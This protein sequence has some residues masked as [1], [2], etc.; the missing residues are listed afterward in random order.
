M[1]EPFKLFRPIS[2]RL[3][4]RET[5]DAF[6]LVGVL[7]FPAEFE[8]KE[9][10]SYVLMMLGDHIE[11]VP[12]VIDDGLPADMV[13]NGIGYA[14]QAQCWR[15]TRAAG[16]L[17][18]RFFKAFPESNGW[19]VFG[20]SMLPIVSMDHFNRSHAWLDVSAGKFF[21]IQAPFD[22]VGEAIASTLTS[23]AV[24]P[25]VRGDLYAV[26]AIESA[27]R[28]VYLRHALLLADLGAGETSLDEFREAIR[29]DREVFQIRQLSPDMNYARYLARLRDRGGVIEIG[30]R[31]VAELE[32]ASLLAQEVIR[33][34]IPEE[35][36]AG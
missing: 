33:E 29:E 34:V 15:R 11:V 17:T 20:P 14:I 5:A 25:D 28:P 30:V 12:N 24:W 36:A 10:A 27:W 22:A 26:P 9:S 7:H 32:K 31:S 35:F 19:V 13:G 1:S 23:Y 6:A 8:I 16:T 18:V 3:M 2:G 21:G 4:I